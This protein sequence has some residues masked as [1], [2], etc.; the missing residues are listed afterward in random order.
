M[1]QSLT[2]HG[3]ANFLSWHRVFTAL[4]ETA[5]REECG[6]N[7][8]QPYWNWGKSALD[9]INS[10]IFDG[11]PGSMGGN[12]AFAPHNCTNA[13]QNNKNCIPA[14][15][16]GGCVTQG[17]FANMSVNLGPISPTLAAA[18]VTALSP[19]DFFRYNPR[20]LRRDV[21]V[22]VSSG[23]TT[24]QNSTD[25]IAGSTSVE[26]FQD[27]MQ[28]NPSTGD[29]GVHGGGHFTIVGD[30]GGDFFISPGDPVFFLHHGQIDRTWWIWQ[31]LDPETRTSQVAG[32]ITTERNPPSRS[33]TLE[34]ILDMGILAPPI[35]MAKAMS[36][37][38]LTG[39]PFCYV[40]E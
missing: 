2:I 6:F 31:N 14:G 33:G 12:G 30:P 34:D 40:Y 26:E 8:T 18:N 25:L 23:W 37:V 32:T 3:T 19:A 35:K 39:G 16:G 9:P 29:F 1:N 36:S 11:S 17:P 27:T 24:D 13:F 10:P 5:L 21:S 7:G 28:G 4:F 22:F 20:C 38:G 15:A